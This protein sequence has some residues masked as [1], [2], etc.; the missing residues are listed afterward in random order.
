MQS[1]KNKGRASDHVLARVISLTPG[2]EESGQKWRHPIGKKRKPPGNEV[3]SPGSHKYMEET[4]FEFG[5][6]D[7]NSSIF[8]L[9]KI[10]NTLLSFYYAPS[11][12]VNAF[13]VPTH[14]VPHNNSVKE[15]LLLLSSFYRRKW[16]FREVN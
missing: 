10:A 9:I 7:S 12:V 8:S 11:S 14:I 16:R 6:L 1:V 2:E 15:E 5:S 3:P 4:G 13:N